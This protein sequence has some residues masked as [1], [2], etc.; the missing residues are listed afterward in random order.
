MSLVVQFEPEKAIEVLLY[1][2]QRCPDMYTAL[3]VLF[4][5]DKEHLSKYGRLI[6]GE[7]YVAMS[8]GPVPSGTYDFIKHVRDGLS[9][10]SEDI[11]LESAFSVDGNR[12]Q[13]SRKPNLELL[14]QSDIECLDAAIK[15]YGHMNFGELKRVSH[16][17]PAYQAADEND[18]ISFEV[19]VKSL[20]KG[21]ILLEYLADN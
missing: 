15:K 19:F 2:A 5:A 6:C 13:P 7:S 12:I 20:P 21:E 3:K 16:S 10:F 17:D 8:H 14:S 4:F 9:V 18:F 1:I 11:G